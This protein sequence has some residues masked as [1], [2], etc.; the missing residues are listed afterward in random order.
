MKTITNYVSARLCVLLL[1]VLAAGL[2]LADGLSGPR[3]LTKTNSSAT[4]PVRLTATQGQHLFRRATFFGKLQARTNNTDTVY[5]GWNSTNDTQ[6]VALGSG[7]SLVIEAPPDS[8]LDL[9]DLYLDVTST[10]DGV[11]VV[12]AY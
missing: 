11:V 12:Y 10:N 5:L 4:V 3:E 8:W 1:S 9:Y 7:A 2:L 6:V